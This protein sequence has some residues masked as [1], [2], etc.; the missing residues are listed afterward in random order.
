MINHL[1]I[2]KLKSYRLL[3]KNFNKTSFLVHF[4]SNR[5]L[6]IN[7][8]VFKRREF[9]TM[10]YHL[11]VDVNLDKLKRNDIE[12]ILFLSRMLSEI[13]T[14]YWSTELE[15]CDLVWVVKRVRHMIETI[16]N[17]IVVFTNHVVNTFIAKQTTMNSNNTDKLNL[18]LV[19][20]FVYLSQFR[21]KMKYKSKKNHVVSNALSKLTSDNEQIDR[22]SKNKLD[23]NTYHE[24]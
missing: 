1:S 10:I 12:F 22:N 2:E 15:M 4:N 20:A 13:E 24:K 16:K 7:I 19:R 18:R 11:K 21:L 17:I 8:D 3:Q 5:Q 23:L 6:Y 14:K 9:E